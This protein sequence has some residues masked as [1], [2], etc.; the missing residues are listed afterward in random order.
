MAPLDA[1]VTFITLCQHF[2]GDAWQFLARTSLNFHIVRQSLS[3]LRF[4]VHIA[5]VQNFRFIKTRHSFIFG[6][7]DFFEDSF[8]QLNVAVL[9]RLRPNSLVENCRNL[10]GGYVPNPCRIRV[11]EHKRG[12]AK[13]IRGLKSASKDSAATS[14]SL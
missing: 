1:R 3:G 13:S 12:D 11:P 2:D 14:T 10:G 7:E 4:H 9:N 8:L 5:I 6:F